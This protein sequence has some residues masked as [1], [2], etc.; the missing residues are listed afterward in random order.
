MQTCVTSAVS[1]TGVL[2]GGLGVRRRADAWASRLDREDP[3]R[4]DQYR[5]E[6]VDF[7]ALAVNEENA[8][9]GRVVTAPTN[10]ATGIIPAVLFY[11]TPPRSRWNTISG[12]L[13][14]PLPA[15]YRCPA[16]NATRS[17]Q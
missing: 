1:R 8:S 7:F 2:P 10:G 11:A 5:Q 13:V 16:S 15:S 12:R 3:E 9:G 17:L 6:R 4:N 14:V